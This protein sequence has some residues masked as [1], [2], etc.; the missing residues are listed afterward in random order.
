MSEVLQ[1]YEAPASR[2]TFITVLCILTFIGSGWGLIGGA[3]QYFSAE[4]QALSMSI[5]KEKASTDIEKSGKNDAGTQMAEKM[6]N[7]MTSA[8]TAE[9][10][11]KTGIASIIGALFC[12]AGAFLMWQ[13][14][15]NGFYLYIAGTLIGIISPFIIYG[16]NNFMS[17]ITSVMVGFVGIVFVILYGV[18]LKHMK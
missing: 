10:L 2:P 6:V 13:L 18:N 12:L 1:D 9:N 15:K 14:K 5:T 8:F 7:S 17:I 3:I 4:K 16:T 11:K